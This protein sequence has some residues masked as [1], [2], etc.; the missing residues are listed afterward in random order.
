MID[1]EFEIIAPVI[2]HLLRKSMQKLS[3]HLSMYS[4]CTYITIIIYIRT[5]D[6]T[7]LLLFY[8]V[9]CKIQV[10]VSYSNFV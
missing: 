10:L 8:E 2:M 6:Q 1:F 5:F 4:I 9:I 3:E 7:I